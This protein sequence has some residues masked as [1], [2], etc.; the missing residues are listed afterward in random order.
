MAGLTRGLACLAAVLMLGATPAFAQQGGQNPPETGDDSMV[1]TLKQM[2]EN[3]D[4]FRTER[5]GIVVHFVLP[6]GW[7]LI[8][9]GIDPKTGEEIKDVGMY[10]LLARRPMPGDTPTDFIFELD[11][12]DRRLMEDL[13]ADIPEEDR[14]ESAQFWGFI[15]AQ[16]AMNA[17]SGIKMTSEVRDINLKEYRKDMAWVPIYYESQANGTRLITFTTV[18]DRKLVVM[19]FLIS[20]DMYEVH[21]GLVALIINNSWVITTDALLEMEKEAGIDDPQNKKK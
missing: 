20:K 18:V 15:N 5:D 4:K 10:A 14:N 8:E 1:I 6:K 11:I 21:K 9:Q 12:Y 19:K 3:L 2:S 7:D 16:I 13:P 17:R